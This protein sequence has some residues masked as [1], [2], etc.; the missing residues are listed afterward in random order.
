MA[1]R[2]QQMAQ[3]MT[4]QP[5]FDDTGYERGMV[6]PLRRN[7]ATDELQFAVP[8]MIASPLNAMQRAI[9]ATR[10]NR[11]ASPDDIVEALS[12]IGGGGLAVGRAPAGSLGSFLGM[13]P[14]AESA[15][16][17]QNAVNDAYDRIYKWQSPNSNIKFDYRAPDA[18]QR[19]AEIIASLGKPRDKSSADLANER[20]ANFKAKSDLDAMSRV[21][22]E[23][24]LRGSPAGRVNY[25]LAAMG[26]PANE[27]WAKRFRKFVDMSENERIDYLDKRVPKIYENREKRLTKIVD[28]LNAIQNLLARGSGPGQFDSVRAVQDLSALQSANAANQYFQFLQRQGSNFREL[29]EIVRGAEISQALSGRK[30]MATPED[31]YRSIELIFP[32]R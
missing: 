9:G 31:F 16:S 3:A 15:K 32:K 10:E 8:G 6:L 20:F 30:P 23:Y 18:E 25:E 29:P 17:L 26:G 11:Q 7:V 12:L 21:A 28:D 13:R 27:S 24:L 1:D 5:L 19:L 4:G 14:S 22:E 2:A